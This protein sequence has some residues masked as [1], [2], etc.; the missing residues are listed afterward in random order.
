MGSMHG[1]SNLFAF[2]FCKSPWLHVRPWRAHGNSVSRS[3]SRSLISLRHCM[4]RHDR[5]VISASGGF[6]VNFLPSLA[7]TPC[8]P[9][10]A[11]MA[12]ALSLSGIFCHITWDCEVSP[13]MHAIPNAFA[14]YLDL[15]L[16]CIAWWCHYTMAPPL[17]APLVLTRGH[18]LCSC[19]QSSEPVRSPVWIYMSHR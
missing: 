3:R 6:P 9:A 18:T 16:L 10:M 15:H 13:H 7:S 1:W 5:P 8:S 19:L 11:A 12:M 4:R 2:A 17:L 14:I